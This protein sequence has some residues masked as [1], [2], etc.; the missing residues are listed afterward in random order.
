MP[1]DIRWADD[2]QSA[3]VIQPSGKWSW[4]DFY[5]STD[6]SFGLL[7][8]VDGDRKIHTILD[9]SKTANWPMNTLV[10]G[11][12]LLTHQHPRQGAFVF[13]GMNAVLN[14]LY[15]IFLQLNAKALTDVRLLTARNIDEALAKLAELPQTDG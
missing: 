3:I 6:E 5:S 15:Q 7:D 1:I 9:W 14:G 4:E 2:A 13:T 8:Q 12:N 10:H 11:K